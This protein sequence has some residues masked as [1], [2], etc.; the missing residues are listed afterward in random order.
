MTQA[1][2]EFSKIVTDEDSLYSFSNSELK[3]KLKQMKRIVDIKLL[4]EFVHYLE[5]LGGND[6]VFLNTNSYL[7]AKKSIEKFLDE[8][9]KKSE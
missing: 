8:R 3:E 2:K 5:D 4:T 1:L 7:T 9:S 6:T